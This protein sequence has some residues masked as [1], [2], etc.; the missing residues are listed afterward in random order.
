MIVVRFVISRQARF[1]A[2]IVTA[3]AVLAGCGSG[4]GQ[5]GAAAI[6]GDTRIPLDQVQDRYG[7]VLERNPELKSR[8][9]QQGQMDE[10]GRQLVSFRVQQELIEQAARKE[11]L[12]VSERR[13]TDDIN[14]SG[15]P[16]AVAQDPF[17]AGDVRNVTRTKLLAVELGRKYLD[18]TAITFDYTQANTRGDAERKARR[19]AAG[20]EEA[21]AFLAEERQSGVPVSLNEHM[22]AAENTQL[23]AAT[24][25]FGAPAGTVVAFEVQPQSGQWLI[26]RI[27]ER[28]TRAT[29]QDASSEEG[30]R[31]E[32]TLRLFG[33]RLLAAMADQDSVRLNP[34]YGVWDPIRLGASPNEDET[35]GFWFSGPSSQS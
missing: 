9:Q 7:T 13:I 17:A 4:P 31:D 28:N 14:R 35:L 22:S 21:A 10:L 20:A 3:G 32:Q 2:S 5:P 26:A 33:M 19:M 16:E 23:A 12:S 25:L 29:A 34:R 8:L 30:S 18:R 15:G 1:V 27:K 6:V 24:P 11:G